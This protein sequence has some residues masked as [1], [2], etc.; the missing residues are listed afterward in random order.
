MRAGTC[1]GPDRL[2][3]WRRS[4]DGPGATLHATLGGAAARPDGD[5]DA[6]DGE[7]TREEP[8]GPEEVPGLRAGPGN[9]FDYY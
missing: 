3:S 5:A 2:D 9:G 8:R 1:A 7:G 6:A 4:R